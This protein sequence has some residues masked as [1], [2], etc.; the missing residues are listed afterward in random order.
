MRIFFA[1]L[2]PSI[3]LLGSSSLGS[4]DDCEDEILTLIAR[5]YE[6]KQIAVI[7]GVSIQTVKWHVSKL[8]RRYG[9]TN[10]AALASVATRER[11][12]RSESQLTGA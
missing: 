2:G 9:V 6:N 8:F 3:R 10:R 7:A 1:C 12:R 4:V 5:G 11:L